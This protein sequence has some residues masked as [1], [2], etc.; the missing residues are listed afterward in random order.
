MVVFAGGPF[1]PVKT[2]GA[3][4]HEV[5]DQASH[6]NPNHHCTRQ[7]DLKPT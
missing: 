7:I 4:R 6:K 3:L 2:Q 1:V 5:T